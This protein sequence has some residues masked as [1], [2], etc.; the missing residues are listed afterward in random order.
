MV[1]SGGVERRSNRITD[2]SPEWRA[3]WTGLLASGD[4]TFQPALCR[5]VHFLNN[6]AVGPE[7]VSLEH[8]LAYRDA[9]THNETS[10]SP[11]VAYRAA[12]NG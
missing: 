9:L 11:D 2:L 5:L 7:H 6:Q 12:V 1:P 3:L 10:K 4:K 8:G